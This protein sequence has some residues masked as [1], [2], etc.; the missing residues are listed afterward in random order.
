MTCVTKNCCLAG[1]GTIYLK[2]YNSCCD[3]TN[4]A[5]FISIGNASSFS[6]DAE[7]TEIKVPN[8]TSVGGGSEC[9]TSCIDRATATITGLCLNATNFARAWTGDLTA[10]AATTS[11]ITGKAVAKDSFIPYVDSAGNPI[12]NV[13]TSSV[14]VTGLGTLGTDYQVKANG[15]YI[16][17]TSTLNF[18]SPI[19]FTG[20]VTHSGYNIVEMLT[21]SSK[22]FILFYDGV[23][24]FGGTPFSVSLYRVKL[25]PVSG[26]PLLGVEAASAE[27]EFEILKDECRTGSGTGTFSQYGSLAI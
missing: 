3:E 18:A 14:T 5:P 15:I 25:K 12:T 6:V 26:I 7:L 10:K 13:T 23:N 27:Y 16:P 19:S 11:A 4:D 20:N 8:Y 9:T 2:E 24:R 17:E 1:A 22:E 21:S